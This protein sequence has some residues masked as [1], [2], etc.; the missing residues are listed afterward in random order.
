MFVRDYMTLN[1]VTVKPEDSVGDALK[2]LKEHS[3]RRLPVMVKDSLVGL[4]TE[5]DLLKASPSAATSLSVWEINYLFPKIKIK[6]VMA[7][8]LITVTA[9]MIL[10]E[11]ALVMRENNISSLPVMEN[12]KLVAIIT[13]SDLFKAFI[14]VLGFNYPSVR[15][16]LAVQDEVGSIRKVTEI[17]SSMN[18]NIIS[19]IVH[20]LKEDKGNIILR[21]ET[22]DI[23][24]VTKAF[25]DNQMKIV[26]VC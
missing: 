21:V 3:I 20:R 16:T 10:E 11:A 22:D 9:D 24:K 23:A 1:P 12:D 17:V 8:E 4:V 2:L 19:L 15:V 7:K 6:D 13:E 26:H 14:D 25:E 18:V 5:Q